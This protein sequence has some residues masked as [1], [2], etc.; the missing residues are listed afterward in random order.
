MAQFAARR[1]LQALMTAVIATLLLFSAV[2]VFSGDPVRALFGPRRVDPEIAA[3]LNETFHFDQPFAKRY[4]LYMGGLV[5]GDLGDTFPRSAFGGA[6]V[7]PTVNSVVARTAPV[8]LRIVGLAVALQ[9]LALPLLLRLMSLRRR[10]GERIAT[11]AAVLVSAIPALV[12]AFL[13]Q[14]AAGRWGGLAVGPA[15]RTIAGPVNYLLPVL[16]LGIGGAATMILVARTELLDAMASPFGKA[17][18]GR[19]V[20]PGRLV[21]IHALK[22]VAGPL[23]ELVLAG[24]AAM[25]TNL[26]VVERIF[27]VPGLGTRMFQAIDRREG[28][29]L[30]SVLMLVVV[31]AVVLSALADIIRAALDPRVR[32]SP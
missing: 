10:W 9:V 11:S 20:S 14:T 15:W 22:P 17:A 23:V 30:I 6:R 24:V 32:T 13:L 3:A 4:L 25:F 8:S 31:V 16:A 7:G 21:R 29:L 28:A 2:T 26:I 18:I 5:S 19:G 27:Q 12:A 1:L